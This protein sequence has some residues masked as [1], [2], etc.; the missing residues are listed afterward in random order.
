MSDSSAIDEKNQELNSSTTPTSYLSNIATFALNV[1][2]VFIIVVLYFGSSGLILYSCKLGQSN[3]LPTDVHCYPYQDTKPN[4]QPISINIFNTLLSDPPMSNKIK[5]PYD[6]FN[7]ENKLLDMFRKYKDEPRSNF[8]ANYFIS[9]LESIT[10]FNYSSFN[11][12]LNLLNQVPEVLILLFGPIIVFIL[13]WIV[14]L[15]DHLYLIYLWFAGMGWFFKTN[16]NDSG[17]GKPDWENVTILN[18]FG[19]WCA[20]WLV[21]LFVILFFFSLPLLSV[22]TFLS[23][24]WCVFSCITYKAELNGKS[25]TSIAVIQDVYKYYK[26]LIMSILSFFVVVSAFSNLGPIP[27]IFS[28]VTL[29]LIYWGI[30]SIDIFKPIGKDGLS[31]VVSYKLAK[32]TCSTDAKPKEKHGLLYNLIFGQ[33]GGNNIK[34]DLK[35]LGKQMSS[36]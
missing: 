11:F 13:G 22:V 34:N 29:C 3:I 10:Q 16:T 6:E 25:I 20:I 18:W 5:F 27:G 9:I 8:L 7:S 14:F 15:M 17:T 28:I 23:M 24:M 32:K 21:I 19:Y 30:I 36:K 35:K 26:L 1:L 12:I 4:I 2:I 31:P 33:S